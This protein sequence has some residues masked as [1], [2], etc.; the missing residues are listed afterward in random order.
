MGTM[1]SKV[2]PKIVA[3]PIAGVM[4]SGSLAKKLNKKVGEKQGAYLLSQLNK[5]L[6]GNVT[7]ELGLELGDLTDTARKYPEVIDC[8]G[9]ATNKTFYEELLKVSGGLEFKRQ[10]ENF[11]DKYGM[12]CSG[13]IDITKPR[14]NEDP[15]QLIPSIL[16]NIR[17]TLPGEHRAKFKH[18]EIEA[19]QAAQEI[20]SQFSSFEKR[21]ISR[22]IK[23]YRNLMGTR[24]NHKFIVIMLLDIYKQALLEEGRILVQ[25]GILR[26]EEDVFYFTLEELISLAEN[27]FLGNLQ[28]IVA[29]REKQHELDQKLIPPRVMTS[30]GEIITGKLRNVQAPEGAIIGTP[31]SAGVVEGTARVVL[32]LE[33]AKLNPGEILV[34]PY[35][36]PGWTPLFISIKGLITEVGGTMTH[37]SV[38]AR[39]YGIPAVVGIDKAT[40]IIPDGAYIRVNG[41][42]GFVQILNKDKHE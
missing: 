12:R 6:P 30:E 27:S 25:K 35:T 19:D 36:D 41:T 5:S 42:E 31:V 10:L 11:L 17:T 34:A 32:K 16:S 3:Y 21:S 26:G 39:E 14:W 8:L 22:L 2:L 24:E 15:T 20:L 7:G 28:E 1:F 23:L 33:D 4:A 37:G 18:G 40:E 29:E 9:K 13:E 38:V